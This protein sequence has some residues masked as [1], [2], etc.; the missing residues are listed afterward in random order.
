M[1]NAEV[2]P[3]VSVHWKEPWSGIQNLSLEM[4]FLEWSRQ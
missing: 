3:A 2:G 1:E 4:C